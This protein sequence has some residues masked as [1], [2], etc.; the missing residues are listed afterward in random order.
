MEAHIMNFIA[1]YQM[2][3]GLGLAE[4]FFFIEQSVLSSLLTSLQKKRNQNSKILMKHV[5][6]KRCFNYLKF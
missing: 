2:V 1:F 3:I 5:K 6:Y 4:G